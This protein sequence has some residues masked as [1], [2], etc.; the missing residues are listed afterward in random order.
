[1]TALDEFTARLFNPAAWV[2]DAACRGMDPALF[3]PEHGVSPHDVAKAKATCNTCPVAVECADAGQTETHGIW[4]GQLPRERR[5]TRRTQPAAR[6]V[7]RPR[8][9]KDEQTPKPETWGPIQHGT[10]AGRSAERRRQLPVCDLC[11]AAHN[12][13]VRNMR[14]RQNGTAT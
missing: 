12:E 1:M 13:Y 7:N 10:T 9:P 4:A 8:K 3:Y 5:T 2:A 6:I 11:K 14:H